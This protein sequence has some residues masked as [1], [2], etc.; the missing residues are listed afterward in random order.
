MEKTKKQVEDI[1]PVTVSKWGKKAVNQYE[2]S[3]KFIKSFESV[4]QA[5]KET[6]IKYLSISRCATGKAKS[7]GGFQWKYAE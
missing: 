1:A 6:G 7:T 3:G 2:L 4:S 5:S